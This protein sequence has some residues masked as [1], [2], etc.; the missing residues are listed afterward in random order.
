[1]LVEQLELCLEPIYHLLLE[2]N[3]EVVLTSS[4][5]YSLYYYP[6]RVSNE[7]IDAMIGAG[8]YARLRWIC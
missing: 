8:V 6:C 5:C 4:G 3:N 7:R 2:A 1:M